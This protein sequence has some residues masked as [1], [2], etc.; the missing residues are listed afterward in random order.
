M[1]DAD[2]SDRSYSKILAA[3]DGSK[4]SMD[5]AYYAISLSEKYNAKLSVL[6]VA[7]QHSFKKTFSSFIA[8]PTYGTDDME[9]RKEEMQKFL[10]EIGKK[11]EENSVE[12]KTQIIEGSESVIRAILEFAENE[13]TDLIIVGTRGSS[14]V[15]KL[16]VG[17]VA[18]GVVTYSHCPVLVVK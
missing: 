10:E 7:K 4:P 3:V 11:A 9:Q 15:K 14:K 2:G 12:V 17:S 8:A 18:E 5:A 16:L 13:K 1:N 6:N